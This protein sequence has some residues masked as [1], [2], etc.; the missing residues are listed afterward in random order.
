M[1]IREWRGRATTARSAEYPHHFRNHVVP[2]LKRVSGFMGAHLSQRQ[3]GGRVEFL[4]LTRWTSMEAIRAFAGANPEKAVV[5]P[6]AIAA[7]TDYEPT[8]RHYEVIEDVDHA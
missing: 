1:V 7:L 3:E 5:E 4:V 8:V 2:E 6:G